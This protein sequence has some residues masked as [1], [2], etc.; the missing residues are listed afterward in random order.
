MRKLLLFTLGVLSF[1]TSYAQIISTIAGGLGDGISALNTSLNF[2]Y[3]TAV[4]GSGNIYIADNLN[5]RIRKVTASTGIISTVAGNGIAGYGGDG[6]AAT[7]ANLNFPMGVTVDGFGNIYIA[8]F[9]NQRIRKITTSTGIISTVAGNGIAAFGGDGS[10]ATL[11][12]LNNP[13]GVA[14]DVSGN[15]YIVDRNNHRIRK[16][17][18]STGIISTVAGNGIAAFGGDGSASTLANINFPR[19]VAVDGTGNIYITDQGNLRIRKVT[20]STGIITTV[21]GNGIQGY[22]GDDSVATSAKLFNPIGVAVDG[23]GNIY[24]ADA[25]NHR[26]RKVTALTGIIST[27]AGNGTGAYGGDDS[28]AT[29]AKLNNP[30]G[31]T[32]DGSGNIYIADASNFR[33][34]KITVST[35][36]ISSVAGNGSAAYRGDGSAAT[37]ANLN[38][39]TGVA[40]DGSGNI[41]IADLYNQ[42][43]RKI[44]KS[45][46]IISTV[47]GNGINAYGGDSSAATLANLNSPNGI[48]VD[49]SGNIYIADRSN[50]RIRKITASTGII[51]TVAGSE[52]LGFGGYGGDGSAA[53][54]ARLNYP[55]GVAIDGSGNIY[56]ADVNNQ[57]IRK[58]TESTGIISTIAGTGTAG[59]TGDGNVANLARLNSPI[60]VTVDG[61]GNIYIA[62]ANNQRIR[63]VTA[64]TGIINTV[65]G[66][67]TLGDGGDGS[68]ATSANL[69]SPSGSA[70]DGSGNIYIADYGNQRIRKVTAF[71]GII[72]TVAGNGTQGNLG[73]GSEAT[74]ANLYYP[75]SVA[76][77]VL[78]NI[79]IADKNN[80]K[81][82]KVTNLIG[83]NIISS[84]QTICAGSAPAIIIGSTPIGATGSYA[85]TWL[86]STTSAT[87][88]FTAMPSSNTIN[89]SPGVLTQNTW[90]KRY[91][92]SSSITDTSAAV[93]IIINTPIANNN[94]TNTSQTICLGSIPAPITATTA[95]GGNGTSYKYKW[96]KSLTGATI[97]F[98]NAG[99]NDSVQNFISNALTQT[100][101][102]KRKV[103]SGVCNADTTTELSVTVIPTITSNTISG[104]AQSICSGSIPEPIT[105]TIATGGNGTT[106]NYKWLKS[107]TSATTGF[108]NAGGNDSIQNFTSNALTQNTWFKRK[109]TSG[110]CNVDTT[111]AL[112]V[113]VKPIPVT[114]TISGKTSGAKLDTASYSVN[115][116]SG[117]V[118][119]W[120]VSGATIQSGTGSNKIQVKWSTT[121]TQLVKVTETSNQGC[122]GVQKSL[123]VNITTSIG[124][125]ELKINNQII[126]YPNPFSETIHISLLNNLKLEKAIIYDLVGNEI[127]NSNKNEIDASS[128]KSGVYLIMIVDNIGNSYSKKLIKN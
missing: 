124:M 90:L 45:T 55:M 43:V 119:N 108:A 69:Y 95:T 103:I 86:R 48:A 88:G 24:I 8:D 117:S 46:G 64:S 15:I 39:P 36:I 92:V 62:D 70:V 50:H 85:Y 77:D 59:F 4:D 56:I 63:K 72:S 44:T 11:A 98:A 74:L 29:L 79:Y 49:S 60:G 93:A 3:A 118:F 96:L 2:P 5:H 94:I 61:T 9:S 116:L 73:D 107:I 37:M 83:N 123:Y 76:L 80:N 91:V 105:A 82:R 17:T 87:S 54:S 111:A 35:G 89:Y 31:I 81:I 102:F 127:I 104:S 115:G 68:I 30:S 23:A 7:L 32:L 22:S 25:S 20:A 71:T 47:A 1:V 42:R 66:N 6:S 38:N 99:G 28:A 52:S 58:V 75:I 10:A 112:L 40:L 114:S 122:I 26:I 106:Y 51:S 34:R 84:S 128:L 125:N 12:N 97:G 100:T 41:F 67:G 109:V 126:I 53:T 78:G 18:A 121:G 16:V 101:W 65:A 33:I 19:G 113:T 14:L 13:Q 57:R 27:I 110:V 120:V 21:S